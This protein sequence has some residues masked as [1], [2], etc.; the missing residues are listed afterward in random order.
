MLI[1]ASFRPRL[2]CKSPTVITFI[3]LPPASLGLAGWVEMVSGPLGPQM[4]HRMTQKHQYFP[5]EW[6]SFCA[7]ASSSHSRLF[8]GL[9]EKRSTDGKKGGKKCLGAGGRGRLL[10]FNRAD[11]NAEMELMTTGCPRF[12]ADKSLGFTGNGLGSISKRGWI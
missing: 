1:L 9:G 5:L 10:G 12:T 3:F 7:I 2:I 4:C 8:K 6:M 11:K